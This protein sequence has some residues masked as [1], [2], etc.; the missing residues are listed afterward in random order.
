[1][2][3]LP[4]LLKDKV[5][6]EFFCTVPKQGP[7]PMNW[8][9][10]VQ[11]EPNGPLRRK[12]FASYREAFARIAAEKKA[13]RLY[14]GTI[15]SRSTAYSPPQRVVKIKR[16]GRP[17]MVKTSSGLLVQKTSLIDWK[18][19]LPSDEEEHSWCTYCRR[20]TVFRWF[21]SHHSLRRSPVAGCVDPT[22]RRCTFCGATE[23]FIR[24]TLGSA[25]QPGQS[26]VAVGSKRRRK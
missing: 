21:T 26:I 11:R 16:E 3:R 7:A 13:G 6:K 24:T 4:E 18:P 1:M 14:D 12:D 10:Y 23:G 15:Q 9:I 2:I 25:A 8:R 20:P 5:Y 17:V 22:D 19:K